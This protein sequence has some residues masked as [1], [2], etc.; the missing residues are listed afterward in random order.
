MANLD[1]VT[2]NGKDESFIN[3]TLLVSLRTTGVLYL[4]LYSRVYTYMTVVIIGVL[5]F[6]AESGTNILVTNTRQ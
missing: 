2:S 1:Y 3:S 4:S 5:K 6:L